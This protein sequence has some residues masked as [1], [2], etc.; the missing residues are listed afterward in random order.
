MSCY[1]CTVTYKHISWHYFQKLHNCS[2]N[3]V[4]YSIKE[5]LKSVWCWFTV[6]ITTTVCQSSGTHFTGVLSSYTFPVLLTLSER[7][8]VI[9]LI[10]VLNTVMH[11][12]Y[13]CYLTTVTTVRLIQNY[14]TIMLEY[15]LCVD[16]N[17]VF[18]SGVF[19]KCIPNVCYWKVAFD[20]LLSTVKYSI[21]A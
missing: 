13:F 19:A 1:N 18:L 5:I 16:V 12:T 4:Q 8:A 14:L 6:L 9:S 7:S 21:I 10:P 3:T 17:L 15:E 2:F 20:C 11:I